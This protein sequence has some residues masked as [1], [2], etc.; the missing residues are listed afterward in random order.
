MKARSSL[1]I[2][3]ALGMWVTLLT[4]A[5]GCTRQSSTH[6]PRPTLAPTPHEAETARGSEPGPLPIPLVKP[7][8]T[9][10][11][12]LQQLVVYD[13]GWAGWSITIKATYD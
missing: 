6:S 10:E 1:L 3:L 2:V 4:F 7:L 5:Q 13:A 11:E 12:A 8:G 9:P